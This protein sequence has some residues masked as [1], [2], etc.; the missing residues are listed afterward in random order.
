MS[1]SGSSS[2]T[3]LLATS[4]IVFLAGLGFWG[5]LELRKR[6][7]VPDAPPSARPSVPRPSRVPDA[8]AADGNP[9]DPED[10]DNPRKPGTRPVTTAPPRSP[11]E[12]ADLKAS[13]VNE[14]LAGNKR[15]D[16]LRR[17]RDAGDEW[18]DPAIVSSMTSL[19]RKSEDDG[20]RMNICR[21]LRGADTAEFRQQLMVSGCSDASSGVRREAVHALRPMASDPLVQTTLKQAL[22]KET[23]AGVRSELQRTLIAGRR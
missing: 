19:L 17:L 2:K 1:P 7:A 23:N 6:N 9:S 5:A 22:E 14:S 4:G 3:L 20:V 13:I 8:V 10:P 11:R 12:I 15:V 18:K 21:Y 16:A